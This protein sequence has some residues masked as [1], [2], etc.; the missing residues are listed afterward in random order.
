MAEMM[1]E[2]DPQPTGC[3]QNGFQPAVLDLNGFGAG[4]WMR[5]FRR[6]AIGAHQLS[7]TWMPPEAKA[8]ESCSGN[9]PIS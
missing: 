6:P 8:D 2:S 7:L 3:R 5:S 4:W 1:E 9:L